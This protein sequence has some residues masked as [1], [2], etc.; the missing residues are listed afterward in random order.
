[1]G[2]N[3]SKQFVEGK[4]LKFFFFQVLEI[5]D[6]IEA[7]IRHFHNVL[8]TAFFFLIFF[9]VPRRKKYN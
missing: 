4:F 9:P 1:M 7:K 3:N 8:G 2:K 6:I 5:L